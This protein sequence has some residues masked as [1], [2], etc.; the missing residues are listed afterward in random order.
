[1]VFSEK[2]EFGG[3]MKKTLILSF[4][5]FIFI[6]LLFVYCRNNQQIEQLVLIE[7]GVFKMGDLFGDG[8]S[9]EKPV[10][11]VE[12]SD[13]YLGKFEV[14][15]KNFRIFVKNTGYK[16]S[17]ESEQNIEAQE[18]YM[19][20]LRTLE[21][22]TEPDIEDYNRLI[23]KMLSY[24]GTFCFENY[25][26]WEFKTDMNW[27]HPY[28]DQMDMDPVT[29]ISW[30]DAIHYC[31]WLSKKEGFPV[32]YN[33]KTGA[34]LDAS[35]NITFDV[36]M[37]KGYRLPTEAEWEYAARE[38]GKKVRFGNGE[39][40]ARSSEINFNAGIGDFPFLE[41]GDY[42]KKLIPVGSFA[43]NSLGLYDMSGN[44][45]EWCS[46]YITIFKSE[47][48]VN[49]YKYGDV[50]GVMRRAVRGGRW[51][52]GADELRVSMRF[53]WE[54]FNRCNNIGF[55]LARSKGKP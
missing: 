11:Q 17:A 38:G 51:G 42:R 20:I 55:R 24:S 9:L 1:M 10:H 6:L 8:K 15:V 45:W 21:N 2:R 53:G 49:P 29:C 14:T 48:Q 12:L 7:G 30:E 18:K 47:A 52:G 4:C 31:N 27:N 54:S 22:S 36:T 23:K 46:D 16:T 19:E 43:P 50:G 34:L 13:F 25:N 35:G 39:N 40:M 26:S 28:Y 5:L 33:L 3:I 32:A 44:V 41:K 37:V